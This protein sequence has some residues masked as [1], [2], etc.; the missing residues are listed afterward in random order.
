MKQLHE[1]LLHGIESE[2]ESPRG[3]AQHDARVDAANSDRVCMSHI[4]SQF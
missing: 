4:N 2:D 1:L 3:E